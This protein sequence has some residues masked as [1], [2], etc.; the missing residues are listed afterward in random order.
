MT[1]VSLE[2]STIEHY[3][4][5]K[6]KNGD[7]SLSL[8]YRNLLLVCSNGRNGQGNDRHCDVSKDDKLIAVNPTKKEDIEKVKYS[9]DGTIESDAERG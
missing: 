3:I 8:D 4:P 7:V 9:K 1:R 2:S 5:R 6:G